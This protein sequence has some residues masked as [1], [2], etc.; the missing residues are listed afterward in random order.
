MRVNACQ[1]NGP[2]R[3]CMIAQSELPQVQDIP[4]WAGGGPLSNLVNKLIDIKPLFGLMQKGARSVLI[5]TAEKKGL[6]WRD[7]V[8]KLDAAFTDSERELA[9][10]RITDPALEYPSYY[11]MGFHAYDEGNLDWLPAF[12]QHVA[13]VSMSLRVWKDEPDLTCDVAVKRLR[14][15]HLDTVLRNVRADFGPKMNE[16]FKVVDAGCGVGLSAVSIAERLLAT[17][18]GADVSVE[19]LD[20]SPYFLAV[21]EREHVHPSVKYR[22]ALAEKTGLG[23]NSCDWYSLQYVIHEVPARN[24]AEIFTEAYRVLKPGGMLSMVDNNPQSKTIQNLPPV[25][26]TLMKSTEPHSDSYYRLDILQLLRTIGFVSVISEPSDHRHR[27]VVAMK[28][29]E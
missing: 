7:E 9:L 3:T 29:F 23:S 13:T 19:G 28:P 27:T 6:Y 8:E 11:T 18:P 14:D 25:L 26:F 15:T 5:G 22:H 20:A 24:I 4:K 12:E 17:T 21:A 10:K 2:T 1:R 16:A